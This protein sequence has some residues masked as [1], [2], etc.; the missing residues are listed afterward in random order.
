MMFSDTCT[1][2]WYKSNKQ[3]DNIQPWLTPF[4][5][6]NQPFVPSPVLTVPS[7][8]AYKFLRRKAWWSGTL[9]SL[10]IFHSLQ[11]AVIRVGPNPKWLVSLY[12]GKIGRQTCIQGAHHVSKERRWAWNR[13]CPHCSQKEPILSISWLWTSNL[14][15]Q[16][17]IYC[18]CL[19]HLTCGTFF[20]FYSNTS[21]LIHTP[22]PGL[23]S[24]LC[25]GPQGSL[26]G[27]CI[28]E[29]HGWIRL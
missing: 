23:Q 16:E 25:T 9:I 24:Q 12:K 13:F 29:A 5:I 1:F 10:R 15:N 14:Q 2:R 18:C 20:C 26:C 19:S 4:P 6:W 7:W 28:Q 11:N 27:P 3:G 17:T 22:Q 8:S 21:K